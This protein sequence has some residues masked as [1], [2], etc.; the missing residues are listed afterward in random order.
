M[1]KLNFTVSKDKCISCNACVKDCPRQIIKNAD[2]E[3]PYIPTELEVDCLKCQH[4]LAI[5]PTA[6]ISILGVNPEECLPIGVTDL[7]QPE[8]LERLIRGR[9][10]VRQ[11]MPESVDPK[12]IEK[13][14]NTVAN[15]PSGCNVRGLRFMVLRDRPAM[16]TLLEK[17]I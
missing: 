4:C 13:M 17:I 11:F 3:I 5:C 16:L 7:P 12:L 10:S 14:L 1:S 15:A 6:A 9:R 2:G 8:Q